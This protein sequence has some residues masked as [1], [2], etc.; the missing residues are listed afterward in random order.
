[1]TTF[2]DRRRA[3][4]RRRTRKRSAALAVALAPL[5]LAAGLA[6]SPVLDV[7]AVEVAG[8]R[9]AHADIVRDAARA[10]GAMVALDL[11]AIRDRVARLPQVKS[12]TVTRDWPG[13]VRI[14][15]VERVPV[16]AVRRP[17]RFDLVDADGVLVEVAP[18]APPGTPVLSVPGEPTRV[19]VNA[20]VDL[21]RALP[22]DIRRH[23][24][25]LSSDDAGSLSFTLADGATVVWGTGERA[26][27]KVRALSL[28]IRQHAR[29][30]D[31][32]VPDRPAVVPRS[33]TPPG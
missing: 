3:E 9:R 29:R 4:L 21:M 8:N 32:R 17:G 6:F 16:V 10:D 7:D 30:Y 1:M 11:S 23:V 5:V 26:E 2:T 22:Q 25:D 19:V 15:V 28:L 24:R 12:A 13:T 18:A 33:T 31:L 20:T 27:E 14:A